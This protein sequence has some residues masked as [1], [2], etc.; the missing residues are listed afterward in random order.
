MKLQCFAFEDGS[1][2]SEI[3][4]LDAETAQRLA[5]HLGVDEACK[6]VGSFNRISKF[7][8]SLCGLNS[9]RGALERTPAPAF[10]TAAKRLISRVLISTN[11]TAPSGQTRRQAGN[12]PSMVRLLIVQPSVFKTKNAAASGFFS[13]TQFDL[14]PSPPAFERLK[15]YHAE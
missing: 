4:Y 11:V 3:A 14:P 5:G 15:S 12:V 13:K 7:D 8:S 10:A 9:K 1:H 6:C 2:G